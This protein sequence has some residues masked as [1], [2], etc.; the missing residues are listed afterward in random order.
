MDNNVCSLSQACVLAELKVMNMPSIKWEF[1]I[2]QEE[3]K[4]TTDGSLTEVFF[5]GFEVV[6]HP[7]ELI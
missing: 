5:Y 1:V 3:H 7:G 2:N 4:A 6:L